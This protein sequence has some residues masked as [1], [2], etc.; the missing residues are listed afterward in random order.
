MS[1]APPY[2][3][4][5]L[6]AAYR[7][8]RASELG[9]ITDRIEEQLILDLIGPASGKRLLDVGC[10]DGVFSV[11]LAQAG[12]D[13][14]GLDLDPRG[15]AAARRRATEAG[16]TIVLAEGDAQSL[17][18][19]DGA[20]DIVVA[21]T[22][23]CFVP[24]PER[25]VREMA[26]VLRPGG[27]LVIGELGRC[28][29]WAAK[30]RIAG[31]LRAKTWRAARFRTAGELKQLTI[32][33]GLLAETARGAVCYPSYGLCARWLSSLDRRVSRLTTFGAAF[34]ALAASK[35]KPAAADHW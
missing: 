32:K 14:T 28:S 18:F 12:A 16:L 2:D 34:I 1:S 11:R 20:F 27:R 13:V 15:L 10:G 21:V 25:A 30:R 9:R 29:I 3:L 31:W 5:E 24:A 35:P 22:V 26:R 8:W 19:A 7:R 23:L 33:A 6:P 4:G 17:P